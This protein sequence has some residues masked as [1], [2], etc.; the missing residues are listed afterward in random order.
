MRSFDFIS[1]LL[2]FIFKFRTY[3]FTLR[4]LRRTGS[5]VGTVSHLPEAPQSVLVQPA[6]LLSPL[7]G[8][9]TGPGHCW[10]RSWWLHVRSERPAMSAVSPCAPGVCTGSPPLLS[11]LRTLRSSWHSE[12]PHEGA[13]WESPPDSL[14]IGTCQ[15]SGAPGD[16]MKRRLSLCA[17]PGSSGSR[18]WVAGPRAA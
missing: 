1:H 3:D 5:E 6:S 18:T 8:Q 2:F 13:A 16:G 11:S 12:Q 10:P 15:P 14:L 4:A 17:A 9:A 7:W